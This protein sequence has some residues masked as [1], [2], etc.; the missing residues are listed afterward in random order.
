MKRKLAMVLLLCAGAASAQMY[1]WKDAKG[2]THYT[3]TP[4]PA[5][6]APKA[7]ELKSFQSGAGGAPL[8]A[9]LAEAAR[10]RPVTLYTTGQCGLCDQARAML[11]TRG[12]PYSEKTVNSADDHAALKQAGSAGELPLLLIGRARQVGFD[13]P[14]WDEALT[15]AG[16][17]EQRMLPAN[18]QQAPATAAAPARQPSAEERAQAAAKA[19]AEQAKSPQRLPPVN[20]PPNFQF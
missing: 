2:V 18:Y 13:Q 20:A 3:D 9:A 16:Y 12:I 7:V 4:P 14:T 11:Q 10:T 6:A 5:S 8:P 1:K 17:P 19:A 15:A